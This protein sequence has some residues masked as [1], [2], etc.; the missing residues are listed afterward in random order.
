MKVGDEN[1][2]ILFTIKDI[3]TNETVGKLV[4]ALVIKEVF[5]SV[6]DG[7]SKIALAI[8]DKGVDTSATDT[9]LQMA[10]NI[11]MIQGGGSGA[12][13]LCVKRIINISMSASEGCQIMPLTC[14]GAGGDIIMKP[15]AKA[16]ISVTERS[17]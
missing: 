3:T 10:A 15:F 5:Q 7:K 14:M 6:S 13:G 12:E 11:G 1:P 16:D 17:V 9:F 4:D 8:T 2:E